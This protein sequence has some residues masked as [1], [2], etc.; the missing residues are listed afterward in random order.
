MSARVPLTEPLTSKIPPHSL[1]AERAVLGAILLEEQESLPKAV[2]ILK[3]TDFYKEGH[4]RI[5]RTMIG[6]FERSEPVDLLILTEELRRSGELEEVG[7]PAALAGLAEEGATQ[8]HLENYARLVRQHAIERRRIERAT[9]IVSAAFNGGSASEVAA[10]IREESEDDLGPIEMT[11]PLEPRLAPP[12]RYLVE[13]LLVG[14]ETTVIFGDGASGKSYFAL[15]AALAVSADIPLPCGF[16]PMRSAAILYL[17][18]ESCREEHEDRLPRLCAGFGISGPGLPILYR[19]MTRALVDEAPKVLAEARNAGVGLVIVD[20]LAPACGAE[21]ETADSAICTMNVLRTFAPMTRLV[22][23]HVSKVG[24]DQRAG[25]SRPFGSVFI[26][27]LARATWEIR[28]SEDAGSDLVLGL[29]HRKNN[30]GRL[31]PPLSLAF[32]FGETATRILPADV[33]GQPDLLIRAS[34]SWRVL[35]LLAGG[36]L[37]LGELVEAAQAAEPSVARTLRR[38]RAQGKVTRLSDGQWGIQT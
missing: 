24:A 17:D 33:A 13:R 22:V 18:W 38:L 25:A 21:P 5:F 8:F 1:E 12:T 19:A 35:K 30:S 23:A 15:A 20:S 9:R 16:R 26:A 6:L 37:P 36:A 27:N 2:E 14:G 34:L 4:R 7:G 10:L 28:R 3:A 32:E 31:I 29:F 11:R